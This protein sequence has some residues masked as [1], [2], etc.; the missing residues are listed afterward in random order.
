MWFIKKQRKNPTP[1]NKQATTKQKRKQL[2][3]CKQ[4]NDRYN[5]L[6]K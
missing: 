1:T 5:V 4:Q 6:K 2:K 3:P